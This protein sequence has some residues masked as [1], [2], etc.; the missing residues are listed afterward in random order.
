MSAHVAVVF[1]GPSAEAAVSRVSA[2]A[3]ANALASAGYAVTQLELNRELPRELAA[4][5]IEAVVPTTHGP[6]GEDGCLQGLLE[7]LEVPYSGSGVL[8]S[9]IAA[10]KGMARRV[11]EQAGLPIAKGRLIH[12]AQHDSAAL[13]RVRAEL[14]GAVIVKPCSGGS[15]IGV[16]RVGANDPDQKLRDALRAAFEVDHSVVI[17]AFRLGDEVTC[18]V[19]EDANGTAVALPPTRI[20]AKAADWYDF[21]SRYGTGGS[22]HQCP[23]PFSP[24]LIERVQTVAVAAHRAVQ[25]RDLSR[26]DLIVSEQTGDVTL[27]EVNTLPGMTP[28][29]LF[30]E[31]A[32]IAG[33]SFEE[34]CSRLAQKALARAGR[35]T[36]KVLEMPD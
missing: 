1:G 19:L 22:E 35:R 20:L 21:K 14:G 32:Q 16:G 13:E 26:V 29:S 5:A 36:P 27:L 9:A 31:A 17:E 33:V 8:A 25:A 2:G 15:A 34:L 4:H 12:E 18:G 6:L 30:P 24:E 11:F 7:V 10:D 3:V 23:A 28:T